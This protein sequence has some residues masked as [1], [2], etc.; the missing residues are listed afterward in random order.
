MSKQ[1]WRVRNETGS[2][3]EHYSETVATLES[4]VGGHHPHPHTEKATGK[5]DSRVL[6]GLPNAQ[7]GL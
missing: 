1:S 2:L 7:L 5:T 3:L 4:V 6:D